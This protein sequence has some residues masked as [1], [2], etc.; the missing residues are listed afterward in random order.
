EEIAELFESSRIRAITV[1]K[2]TFNNMTGASLL[3]FL[4]KISYELVYLDV[5]H[6]KLDDSESFILKL[7]ECSIGRT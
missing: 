5:N 6:W 7:A 1:D 4:A 3:A 2:D